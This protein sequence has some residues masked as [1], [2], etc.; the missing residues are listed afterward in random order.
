MSDYSIATNPPTTLSVVVIRSAAAVAIIPAPR[1]GTGL[2]S[3]TDGIVDAAQTLRDRVADDAENLRSDLGLPDNYLQLAGGTMG[4][5]AA[6]SWPNG[7]S[8]RKGTTDL[9]TG[10][11]KGISLV[12]SLSYEMNYQAGVLVFY[13]Q[14]GATERPMMLKSSIQFTGSGSQKIKRTFT[15]IN[16]L[17]PMTVVR[18]V[19]PGEVDAVDASDASHVNGIIGI[20]EEGGD[21]ETTCAITC[22]GQASNGDFGFSPGPI[23]AGASGS[24]T[25]DL[26]GLAFIKVLGEA[27]DSTHI[28]INLGS[29][30]RI[31]ES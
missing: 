31:I 5:D 16:A 28:N 13:E 9:G 25:Q 23:Y 3:V 18:E 1:S 27:V 21:A 12:C 17:G 15:R 14:D 11:A 26:T 20:D 22:W 29:P 24:I 2:V 8:I 30:S 6:I 19:N 7:S 10:G 4:T